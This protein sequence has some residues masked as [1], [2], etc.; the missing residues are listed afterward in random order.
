M[1][2]EVHVKPSGKRYVYYRC[3]RRG[4]KTPCTEPTLPENALKDQIA[5]EL[6]EREIR[7]EMAQW[8][9]EQLATTLTAEASQL[10]SV[11][12]SID[13]AL[14]QARSQ[15]DTLLTLRLR[16]SIDDAAYERRRLEVG[17]RRAQLELRL[18]QPAPTLDELLGRVDLV[19]AFAQRAPAAFLHGDSVLQRQ[20]L[21]TV[22]SNYRVTG[23]KALYEAKNPFT[24]FKATASK[25]LWCTIVED[26]RT[27]LLKNPDFYLPLIDWHAV[28]KS[29]NTQAA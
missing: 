29:R 23:R 2:G 22:G 28:S 27:W 26:V 5:K 15:E 25:S 21:E 11:R 7:P 12:E 19:L 3:H 18:E 4:Q 13:N 20:I 10:L 14:K 9:R 17:E 24:F 1:V 8:I 6:S 16:G